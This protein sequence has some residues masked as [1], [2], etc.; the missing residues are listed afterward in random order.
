MHQCA[1]GL[2]PGHHASP[3][4][5]TLVAHPRQ[6]VPYA[7]PGYGLDLLIRKKGIILVLAAVHDSRVAMS[8]K[9]PIDT[10]LYPRPYRPRGCLR[11]PP[12]CYVRCSLIGPQPFQTGRLGDEYDVPRQLGRPRRREMPPIP[13]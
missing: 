6:L 2:L 1:D 9:A 8:L 10:L 4:A 12:W 7:L 5:Y 13:P 3:P 11:F